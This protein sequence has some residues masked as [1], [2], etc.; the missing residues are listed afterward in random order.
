MK[1]KGKL[2]TSLVFKPDVRIAGYRTHYLQAENV[3]HIYSYLACAYWKCGGQ[4][5]IYIPC[6]FVLLTVHFKDFLS[7]IY[8]V[9]ELTMLC[10]V[11]DMYLHI[12]MYLHMI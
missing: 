9:I 11:C 7:F 3:S 12:H 1:S 4:P 6:L 10:S 2:L 8:Y 5:T